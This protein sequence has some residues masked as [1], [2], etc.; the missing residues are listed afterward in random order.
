MK[1]MGGADGCA[2]EWSICGGNSQSFADAT[3]GLG[4]LHHTFPH[5]C[6]AFVRGFSP[7]P[8]NNH[9]EPARNPACAVFSVCKPPARF[10]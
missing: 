1:N 3:V 5:K 8:L 9:V 2:G 6:R 4:Y 10:R 7:A